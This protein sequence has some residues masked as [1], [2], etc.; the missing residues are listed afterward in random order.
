MKTCV[1][2]VGLSLKITGYYVGNELST[3]GET[4]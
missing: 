1:N 3:V 2:F 4:S